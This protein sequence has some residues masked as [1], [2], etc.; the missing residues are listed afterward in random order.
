[1]PDDL[2]REAVTIDGRTWLAIDGSLDPIAFE[3]PSFFR[4]PEELA[5]LVVNRFSKAG[6]LVLDPFCGLGTTL[7]AAGAVGRR[8]IGIEKDRDRFEFASRRIK[9]PSHVI[10]A[11]AL[12]LET[13]Q[14][15]ISDLIFT[16]PPYTSFR[17]WDDSGFR[18]YWED[19]ESIFS[20]LPQILDRAG[21]LVVE[22]SNVREANGHVRPVAFEAVQRLRQWWDFRGEVVRCNT[23]EES[24][25]PGYDHAYLLVFEPKA[26]EAAWG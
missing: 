11:S 14:L 21:R 2:R 20:Y 26:A 16:S 12:D 17:E 8:A 6:D 3:G 4:F 9:Q 5:R 15:P 25:G 7:V 1:M 22:V 24:A 10:H 23:G 19:F 13:L 18:T